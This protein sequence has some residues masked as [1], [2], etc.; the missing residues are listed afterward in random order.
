MKAN[1][2]TISI[3]IDKKCDKDC[4]YC[5]S[6]M[7]GYVK[8]NADLFW[9]NI[10][11]IKTIAR[12][13]S[14]TSVLITGKSEPFLNTDAISKI[15]DIFKDYPLE[16]QTNGIRLNKEIS[17]T[18]MARAIE[19]YNIIALSIDNFETFD[20]Y[21]MLISILNDNGFVV[22]AT[23]NVTDKIRGYACSDMIVKAQEY[24]IR[25]LSFRNIDCPRRIT[26]TNEAKKSMEWIIKHKCQ[27][28]YDRIINEFNDIKRNMPFCDAVRHL[29]FGATVWDIDR[30]AVTTFD[31]CIQSE[32]NN[33]DIRSLIYKENGHCYTSWDSNASILF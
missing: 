4:P 13:S 21:S 1:D 27:E 28:Q 30:L 18:S 2:L 23:F 11:K 20:K 33:D 24:G 12:A 16:I 31:R 17:K 14:V 10:N 3:P 6:K 15:G 8:S 5:I 7:T 32:N 25:Q 26:D 22:R 29:P 19:K 9:R